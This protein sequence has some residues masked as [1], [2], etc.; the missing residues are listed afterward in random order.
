[1]T[2]PIP[3]PQRDALP[4]W[5]SI[6]EM[7]LCAWAA[8][9]A[10]GETIE[11]HRGFLGLDRT[12]YGLPMSPED[13]AAL[14]RMATRAF[15]LAER[16]F[17]HPVQRRLGPDRFSYLAIARPRPCNAPPAAAMLIEEEAA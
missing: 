9:A 15:A 10:P 8:Q 13:R 12:S 17:V 6:D 7:M 14:I 5:P 2:R 3:F 16:G 1:M 11:Y 4:R